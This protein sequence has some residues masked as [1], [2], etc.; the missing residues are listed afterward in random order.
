M[1]DYE[2]LRSMHTWTN[3]ALE[4]YFRRYDP[5][6]WAEIQ[7]ARAEHEAAKCAAVYLEPYTQATGE[8]LEYACG[9]ALT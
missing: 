5:E 9:R 8:F 7:A 4:E 2:D 3:E 1:D 6:G